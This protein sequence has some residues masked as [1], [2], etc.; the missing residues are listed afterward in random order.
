MVLDISVSKYLIFGSI[1]RYLDIRYLCN[2]SLVYVDHVQISVQ[3]HLRTYWASV[4]LYTVHYRYSCISGNGNAV[5]CNYVDFDVIFQKK[6]YS[7]N[8]IIDW[9]RAGPGRKRFLRAGPEISARLTSLLQTWFD[10]EI[11]NSSQIEIAFSPL[12]INF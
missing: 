1:F 3:V 11:T 10:I 5:L 12:S 7:S 6:L 4:Q 2:P 8:F 9:F